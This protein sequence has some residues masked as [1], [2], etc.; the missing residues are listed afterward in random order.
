MIKKSYEG[1]IKK[2][3]NKIKNKKVK[4]RLMSENEVFWGC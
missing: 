4:K 2:I 1:I 3:L